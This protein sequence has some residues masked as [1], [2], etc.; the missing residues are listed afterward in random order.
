MAFAQK[1]Y[2]AAVRY[3]RG[4]NIRP[5]LIASMAILESR[6][7]ESGLAKRGNNLF[8]IKG[9]G[10][11]GTIRLETREVINGQSIY[12]VEPFAAYKTVDDSIRAVVRLLQSNRYQ[13]LNM[14]Q[15]LKSQAAAVQRAGY[16]TDPNYSTAILRVYN[17]NRHLFKLPSII[18]TLIG[19]SLI[20]VGAWNLKKL[21]L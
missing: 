18:P 15:S 12:R 10:N 7:G 21:R 8:G 13:Q 9:K 19:L 17:S 2:R 16:A 20:I 11:A 5:E 1:V 14:A 4:T 3:T 6:N